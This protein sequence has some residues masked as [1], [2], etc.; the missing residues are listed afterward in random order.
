M[1]VLEIDPREN[2][3]QMLGLP[4]SGGD[5]ADAGG[6]LY[7]QNLKP[8]DVLDRVVA[9]RLK[10]EALTRRVLASP[11]YQQFSEGAPGL[12]EVAILGHALRLVRG[13][14]PVARA[15]P[16][17]TVVLDAPATGHGVSLLAAPKLLSEVIEEGPFG[18]MGGELA[19]WVGDEERTGVVVVTTPEEMPVQEALE[20]AAR[21]DEQLARRP[22]LLVVNHLYPPLP[23]EAPRRRCRK[24]A[25]T[26]RSTCGATGAGSRSARWHA[27]T[28]PGA[29]RGWRCR[30]CRSIGGPELVA[31]LA[32]CL[33]RELARGPGLARGAVRGTG[34]DGAPLRRAPAAHRRRLRRR[35]Q[36]DA[37]GRPR[38][39]RRHA[40]GATRW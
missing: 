21:L 33:G 7:L 27:S 18:H 11:V 36:D 40:A 26:R 5:L 38:P 10:I 37:G 24:A 17:D 1:L 30:S 35:R 25:T 20:L 29:A 12:K 13:I 19:E 23:E 2:L 15:E 4:P 6:G 16:F 9:E 31:A 32:E 22:D 39:R 3:H 28:T 14:D 8:R 34:P